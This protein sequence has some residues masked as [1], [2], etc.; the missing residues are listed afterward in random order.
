MVWKIP[1]G[2]Y[3]AVLRGT[4]SGMPQAMF[5]EMSGG[6]AQRL[7]QTMLHAKSEGMPWVIIWG[8]PRKMAWWRLRQGISKW[9]LLE[10]VQKHLP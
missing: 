8:M 10:I 6:M 9:K 5:W 1:R 4:S 3:Q 7:P 2:K